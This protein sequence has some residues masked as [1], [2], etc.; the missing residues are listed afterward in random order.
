MDPDFAGVRAAT[1]PPNLSTPD[2]TLSGGLG[3]CLFEFCKKRR[4]EENYSTLRIFRGILDRGGPTGARRVR[5]AEGVRG[6]SEPRDIDA[7]GA[8]LGKLAG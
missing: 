1:Y 7:N 5:E 8:E 4:T 2:R 6:A 3:P